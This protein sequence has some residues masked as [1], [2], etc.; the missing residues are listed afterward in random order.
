MPP[1]TL[2]HGGRFAPPLSSSSQEARILANRSSEGFASLSPALLGSSEACPLS[3]YGATPRNGVSLVED[4]QWTGENNVSIKDAE[5]QLEASDLAR[6]KWL[7][8]T[9]LASCNLQNWNERL[10]DDV[11]LS[12]RLS[13]VDVAPA[14]NLRGYSG[15]FRAVGKKQS[16]H[17]LKGISSGLSRDLS[18]TTEVISGFHLI[19]LGKLALR[20]AQIGAR[21]MPIVI[22][23]TLNSQRKIQEMII[24][25]F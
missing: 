23:M 21:H 8:G 12:L 25:T 14:G 17:V 10:A 19:L 1:V 3:Y 24:A 7:I 5:R 18:I 20:T 22:Y 6:T 13:A 15:V 11:V 2:D 4:Y 16:R 9:G